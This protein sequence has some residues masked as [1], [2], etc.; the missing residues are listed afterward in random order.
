[1]D[2][3]FHTFFPLPLT[4]RKGRWH[5]GQN[6]IHNKPSIDVC[7]DESFSQQILSSPSY[8]PDRILRTGGT[9]VRKIDTTL[10][11]WKLQSVWGKDKKD[12]QNSKHNQLV[13]ANHT[14]D[15]AI[16]NSKIFDTSALLPQQQL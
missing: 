13:S 16:L 15:P 2:L 10:T 11:L 9:M 6:Q 7:D 8:V 5:V 3:S 12:P 14:E 4:Y 1:M